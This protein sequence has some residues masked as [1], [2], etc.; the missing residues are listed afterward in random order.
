MNMLLMAEGVENSMD[1]AA[2]L[3]QVGTFLTEALTW[4]GDVMTYV[5]GN[6]LLFILCFGI[7]IAGVSIGFLGRLIRLG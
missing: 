7:P 5:S 6:P 3:S 1:L 2:T 4:I